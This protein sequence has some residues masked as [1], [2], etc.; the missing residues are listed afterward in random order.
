MKHYILAILMLTGAAVHSVAQTDDGRSKLTAALERFENDYNL[1]DGTDFSRK[2]MSAEAWTNL[3]RQVNKASLALDDEA[4]ASNYATLATE[5]NTQMDATDA[6]L[7]LF[8]SYKAMIEGCKALTLSEVEGN[9]SDC[10]MNNDDSLQTAISR[11]NTAFVEYAKIQEDNIDMRPFL[12]ENL[13]FSKADGDKLVAGANIEVNDITGWDERYSDVV[14]WTRLKTESGQLLLRANWTA[15]SVIVEV[16][17]QRMLPEGD[18]MLSLRWNSDMSNMTNLSHFTVGNKEKAI[19]ISTSSM[20]MQTFF[21]TVDEG[22]Q[23]FD[24]VIGLKK[25]NSG[26]APAQIQVDDIRLVCEPP[27][28]EGIT[29]RTTAFQS[30]ANRWY[31]LDGRSLN[32]KP[33]S[34]GI[35]VSKGKKVVI[36]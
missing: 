33:T 12:G 7:R 27:Y 29:D 2:T 10:N 4:Q 16:S 22:G 1:Q 35:Y 11:L 36:K 17:K 25:L 24:I 28:D 9:N 8:K 34:P 18:Y 26:N 15:K 13:D 19:G 21:F 30:A 14:D 6:S 3:L 31:T 5:L 23:P 20:R 32:G